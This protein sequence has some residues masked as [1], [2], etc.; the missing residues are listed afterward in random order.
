MTL[1]F[2]V[3]K[4][5]CKYNN[6]RA[7]WLSSAEVHVHKINMG[8]A[9]TRAGAPTLFQVVQQRIRLRHL[10]HFTE[11]QYLYWI[12]NFVRYH[13][14]RHPREMGTLEVEQFLSYLAIQ[15]EVAPSTQ[16]QA[17]NALVFLFRDVLEQDLGKFKN[18]RWA[19]RRETIPVVLTQSEVQAL[20]STIKSGSQ[21]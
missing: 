18:I 11:K 16:N 7:K 5:I 13:K 3:M 20:L 1:R 2:A 21:Q 12:R 15:R 4:T 8:Q 10:S 17:L 14:K 6:S 19:K 9:D